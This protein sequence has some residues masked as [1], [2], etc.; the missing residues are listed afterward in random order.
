[1]NREKLLRFGIVGTIIAA[2]CCFT[3]VLVLLFAAVGLSWAVGY[4]DYVLFPA[5]FAF[6][7]LTGYALWRKEND[8]VCESN[9]N[10]VSEETSL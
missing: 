10:P 3:P 7:A 1:M 9:S 8:P 2:L 4:L 6:I 5:L